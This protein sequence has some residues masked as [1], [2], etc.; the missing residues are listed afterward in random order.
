M[1]S[2][3]GAKQIKETVQKLVKKLTGAT[4]GKVRSLKAAKKKGGSK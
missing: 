1:K 4:P 2:K 3:K